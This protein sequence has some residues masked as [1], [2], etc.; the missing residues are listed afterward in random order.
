MNPIPGWGNLKRL[1]VLLW[2]MEEGVRYFMP[3]ERLGLPIDGDM[4]DIA[5]KMHICHIMIALH[6]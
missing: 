3:V 1:A 2:G 4:Q 5:L 6:D